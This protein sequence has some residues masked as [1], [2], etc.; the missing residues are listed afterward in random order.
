M[1]LVGG[2]LKEIS[3]FLTSIDLL[4]HVI[5]GVRINCHCQ[6]CGRSGEVVHDLRDGVL[7]TVKGGSARM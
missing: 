2:R 1:A 6:H 3:V 7:T 4:L 5:V